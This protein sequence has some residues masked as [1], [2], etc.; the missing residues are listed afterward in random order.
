MIEKFYHFYL[1]IMIFQILFKP[2][3]RK[4]AIFNL[5]RKIMESLKLKLLQKSVVSL[6]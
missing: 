4:K 6:I 3:F 2:S 5:Y 1:Q